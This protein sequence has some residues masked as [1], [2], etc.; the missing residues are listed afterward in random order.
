MSNK[1]TINTIVITSF[2]L[3]LLLVSRLIF[4]V[5]FSAI[6]LVISSSLVILS[7]YKSFLG[8][9]LFEPIT[10]FNIFYV[11][12]FIL[13]PISIIY[14][15]VLSTD[16]H[17]FYIYNNLYGDNIFS[18]D[19]LTA[20]LVGFLGQIATY[21][22]YYAFKRQRVTNSHV[23]ILSDVKK[24]HL[25]VR[26][27]NYFIA[28]SMIL[29]MLFTYIY[30]RHNIQDFLFSKSKI[31]YGT[32]NIL[33]V[34]IGSVTCLVSIF[35][36]KRINLYNG[37]LIVIMLVLLVGI[38]QRAYAVNLLLGI[39]IVL[40]YIKY[41]RIN[42]KILLLL[43]LTVAMVLILGNIRNE[44]IGREVSSSIVRRV[45]DEF[46]MFD[47]LVV[48]INYVKRYGDFG[49]NG[50][51]YL[52]VFNGFLSKD[53]WPFWVNQFDHQHTRN[54]FHGAY[55]GAVPTS[56]FGSLYLNFGLVFMPA[57]ALIFGWILGYFRDYFSKT[58]LSSSSIITYGLFASLIYDLV[59]VGDIGREI[60]SFL[61]YLGVFLIM[62]VIHNLF[63]RI[64]N[65]GF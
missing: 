13:R 40:Y 36:N 23:D 11:F 60:W 26:V 62:K 25:N 58:K 35:L 34:H 1:N 52:S 14:G 24:K 10:V 39:V 37:I 33:W 22:G 44:S 32:I 61:V 53:V 2:L 41:R 31:S 43:M 51:N 20:Q 50:F 55:S 38:G 15:S 46:S 59:R 30:G 54:I 65:H 18:E 4:M 28:F 21:I 64:N 49:Y 63:A 57:F 48:S 45:I 42:L 19:I 16:N 47:M 7:V 8:K 6:I 9:H 5:S 29:L 27:N 3:I 12:I 17:V 56:I